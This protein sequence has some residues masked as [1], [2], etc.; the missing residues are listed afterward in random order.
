MTGS[1]AV[2]LA[3]LVR[4]T[5]LLAFAGVVG[6]LVTE[7]LVLPRDGAEAGVL[8][9]RVRRL[10]FASLGLLVAATGADLVSRALTMTG[11]GVGATLTA[12]PLVLRRTHFGVAWRLR[13]WAIVLVAILCSMRARWA[14]LGAVA[15]MLGVV[16]T[17]AA[18]G[19]AA[20]WGDFTPTA[21]A[22]WLHATAALA[23]GGGL[24][25]SW[26]C[27]FRETPESLSAAALA[28]IA[29]RFSRLAGVCA[30]TIVAT[31]L[32]NG[33][34]EVAAI[35]GLWTSAYGRVLAVKVLV[36]LGALALGAANRYRV[37]PGLSEAS[38][39]GT[40]GCE[41][42]GARGLL[43]R[44]VTGEAILVVVVFGCTAVLA[45]LPPPRHGSASHDM[46]HAA[47][48]A[49]AE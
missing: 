36:V 34:V 8:R 47:A 19:H 29:R 33:F 40:Q 41:A 17:L 25:C 12:L 3:A 24:L 14:R 27:V 10:T 5:N 18:T 16:F 22:D 37:L 15:A 6:G 43:A 9:G 30:C 45:Q 1:T 44:Y 32:V 49:P 48:H 11:A 46:G 42:D 13:A 20:D 28:T 35:P 4:W 2:A 26:W 7:L 31:G 38:L 39:R 23:W 21:F